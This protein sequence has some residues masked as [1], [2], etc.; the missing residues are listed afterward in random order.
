MRS[1][2]RGSKRTHSQVDSDDEM[3]ITRSQPARKLAASQ[4]QSTLTFSS[5]APRRTTTPPR[6][7]SPSPS[8]SQ[9]SSILPSDSASH[10]AKS[11]KIAGSRRIF[12][13]LNVLKLQEHGHFRI[14]PRAIRGIGQS[15]IS[16]IYFHGIEVQK[17]EKTTWDTKHRWWICKHCYEGEVF[18]PWPATSTSSCGSHLRNKH[19]ILPPGC[20]SDIAIEASS[21][22]PLKHNTLFRPSAGATI[23]STGSPP[24]TRAS[25]KQPIQHCRSYSSQVVPL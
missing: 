25:K 1:Q 12:F 20:S 11:T 21:I 18:K 3:R 22:D 6:Y 15:R 23:I 16:W 7:S 19:G 13:E 9:S 17:K 4:R 14:Q 8:P 5:Q 24:P 10:A 2:L